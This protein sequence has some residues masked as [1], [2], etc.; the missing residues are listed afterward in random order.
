[1]LNNNVKTKELAKKVS[2]LFGFKSLS[3]KTANKLNEV[4]SFLRFSDK[5]EINSEGVVIL[6]E[7]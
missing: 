5:L 1:M 6:K 2:K 7:D 3:Q 4:I